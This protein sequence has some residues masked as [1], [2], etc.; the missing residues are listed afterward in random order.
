MKSAK[1]TIHNSISTADCDLQSF[2]KNGDGME[3]PKSFT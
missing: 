3:F 2:M 1:P